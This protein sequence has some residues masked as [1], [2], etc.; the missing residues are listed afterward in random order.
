MLFNIE[1]LNDIH[2]KFNFYIN[3]DGWSIEHIKAQHSEIVEEKKI[4]QNDYMNKEKS[5]MLQKRSMTTN[6]ALLTLID[7]LISR[8][9]N[10]VNNPN[11]T[12]SDFELLA[13]NI[14]QSIDGFDNVTMHM[15]GN[16]ALLSKSDNSALGNSPFYEKRN[17][18]N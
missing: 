14:N 5:S 15:L 10:F 9:D 4:I 17:I 13:E 7:Q 18:L 1:E 3:K 16:L 8:I 2:Q 11:A 12:K 6:Q